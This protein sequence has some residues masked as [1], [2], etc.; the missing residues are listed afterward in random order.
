MPER[1]EYVTESAETSMVNS[2]TAA[3][4]EAA[5]NLVTFARSEQVNVAPPLQDEPERISL[6]IDTLRARAAPDL[7]SMNTEL[8]SLRALRGLVNSRI[9]HLEVEEGRASIQDM[10]LD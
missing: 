4:R 1:A 7:T 6:L 9:S 2:R 5:Q 10:N 8:E 3:E